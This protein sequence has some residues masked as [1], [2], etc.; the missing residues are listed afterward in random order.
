[1]RVM[2]KWSLPTEAGNKMIKDGEVG[3][4]LAPLLEAMKPEAAYWFANGGNRG[5]L[6]VFNLAESWDLPRFTEPLWMAGCSSVEIIP[7]MN[8]EEIMKGLAAA[9]A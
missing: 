7:V 5:G 2:L 8:Q 9:A 1:M 6:F 4:V 3:K